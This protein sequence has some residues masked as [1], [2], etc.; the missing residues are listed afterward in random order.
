MD[1]EHDAAVTDGQDLSEIV[2]VVAGSMKLA[3]K[4]DIC[5]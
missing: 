4:V 5:T 3:I 1:S 2:C